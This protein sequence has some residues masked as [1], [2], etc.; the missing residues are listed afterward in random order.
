M[1]R[2]HA[3]GIS[4]SVLAVG[5]VV[6]LSARRAHAEATESEARQAVLAKG[7]RVVIAQAALSPSERDVSLPGEVKAW[8]STTLYAKV[9]GYLKDVRTDKG[10]RVKKGQVLATLESPE[11]DQQVNSAQADLS[12]KEQNYKRA[13]S[14]IKAAVVSQQELDTAAAALKVAQA[15]LAQ[16]KTMQEYTEIRAPFDGVITARYTDPGALLPAATGSTTSAQPFVD[17]Q[18]MSRL[19]IYVYLSQEDATYAHLGDP[20]TVTIDQRPGE[21][22][23]GQVDRLSGNL[24]ARSRT[25]LCEVDLDNDRGV[26]FPGQFVRVTLHVKGRPVPSVPAES[27]I[28]R[29]AKLYVA[30]VDQKVAHLR[31][32]ETGQDDG[33]TVEIRTGVDGG[34]WVALNAGSEL[35]EQTTV[36][37]LPLA[38]PTVSNKAR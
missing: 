1:T 6:A 33:K 10:D 21:V 8:A 23:H 5:G 28:A 25:M 20:A 18:D 32:V 19:R 4:L 31:E 36:D 11:I 12:V 30:V 3:I 13:A 27:L 14:L 37:P 38:S 29:G 35:T 34:E 26:L 15:S 9:S 16:A 2:L 17:L 24:D 7:P 22:L